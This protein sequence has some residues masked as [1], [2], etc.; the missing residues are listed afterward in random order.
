MNDV[1]INVG[2]DVVPVERDAGIDIG[3]CVVV[4]VD[5]DVSK[6]VGV[7][8]GVRPDVGTL[9]STSALVGT[10]AAI[11][12]EVGSGNKNGSAVVGVKPGVTEGDVEVNVG[13][14]LDDGV[15]VSFEVD[16][17]IGI[18]L[19]VIWS[20]GAA[21]GLVRG[22]LVRILG[23]FDRKFDLESEDGSLIS[24]IFP[25]GFEDTSYSS[26]LLGNFECSAS[27][28]PVWLGLVDRSSSFSSFLV[29]FEGFLASSN[30]LL[31][32]G[33]ESASQLG[34][35]AAAGFIEGLGE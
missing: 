8:V 5:I 6:D 11:G 14:E 21:V 22:A 26:L 24:I 25:L 9:V 7:A 20:N 33:M 12:R 15:D 30:A 19:L 29:I 10:G 3:T 28:S 4:D 17:A 16:A 2:I 35:A 34:F 1:V 18:K 27:N 31:Q 23:K 32:E 13:F